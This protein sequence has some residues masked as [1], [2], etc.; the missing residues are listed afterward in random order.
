MKERPMFNLYFSPGACSLA[1][2][3]VLEEL[4]VAYETHRVDLL[5]GEQRSPE[6]LKMNPLGRVPTLEFDG[7]ILTECM[8]I[9][10]FLGGAFP[11]RGLWPRET[12][13]QAAALSM[14]SFLASSVHPAYST[15][16][17][18]ERWVE[19]G[20]CIDAVRATGGRRFF[21]FLKMIE[22]RLGDRNWFMGRQ[23][24]VVDPYLLV[25]YRWGNRKGLDVK[26]L[27]G[28]TALVERL[29]KRPA[30]R[31]VMEHEGITLD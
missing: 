5:K 16:F 30:V 19:E 8:A 24:T 26:S 3:I 23:Y 13:D 9:L 7:R 17:R 20:A 15:F 4:G 28:Y 22:A 1:P 11:K 25:F 29:L 10:T 18:P 27:P 2:H 14:M 31:R 12:L 21:D 6:Y